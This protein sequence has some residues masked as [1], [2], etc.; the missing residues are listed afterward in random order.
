MKNCARL[1]DRHGKIRVLLPEVANNKGAQFSRE[2][3]TF[4]KRDRATII[5]NILS[6]LSRNPRGKRKS[7]II[8]SANLSNDMSNKYLDLLLLNGFVEVEDGVFYKPTAKG[9]KLLQSLDIEYLKI[10]MRRDS[11]ACLI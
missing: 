8:Q 6:S 4:K 7:N 10:M 1:A 9:L 11:N 3:I 5:A 2:S